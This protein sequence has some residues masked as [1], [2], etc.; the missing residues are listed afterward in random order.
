M[1]SNDHHTGHNYC[2]F[3]PGICWLIAEKSLILHYNQVSHNE[4]TFEINEAAVDY[5]CNLKIE[6][7]EFR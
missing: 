5:H 1:S 4:I 6:E 2:G 7:H 3:F